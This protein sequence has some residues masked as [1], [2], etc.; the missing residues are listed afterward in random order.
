MQNR[1]TVVR[2]R[3][4]KAEREMLRRKAAKMKMSVSQYIL[5]TA[6]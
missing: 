4:T 6:I 1:D 2:C 5:F 3:V